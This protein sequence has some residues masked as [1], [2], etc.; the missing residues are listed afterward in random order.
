[1]AG[2]SIKHGKKISS[3][4]KAECYCA[5]AAVTQEGSSA[6]R[7]SACRKPDSETLT[8]VCC[9]LPTFHEQQIIRSI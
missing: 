5:D 2:N 1:V 6:T 4:W 8:C 9:S 7:C 3:L